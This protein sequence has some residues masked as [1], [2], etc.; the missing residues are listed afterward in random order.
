MRPGV[1]SVPGLQSARVEKYEVVLERANVA[2]VVHA[3]E[4]GRLRDGLGPMPLPCWTT[5]FRETLEGSFSAVSRPL[6]ARVGA[7]CSI[8]EI[9]TLCVPLHFW[10]QSGNYVY[11]SIPKDFIENLFKK[12][13]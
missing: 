1:F 2:D 9:Y 7:F 6:T 12:K 13:Y 3:L 11:A 5:N 4:R 10:S 8:F